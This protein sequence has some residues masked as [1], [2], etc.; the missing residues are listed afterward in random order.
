[1]ENHNQIKQGACAAIDSLSHFGMDSMEDDGEQTN[2]DDD[3]ENA[4]RNT[5]RIDDHF[6]T[7]RKFCVYGLRGV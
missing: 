5:R 7:A 3:D 2:D 1:M 4:L 6:E